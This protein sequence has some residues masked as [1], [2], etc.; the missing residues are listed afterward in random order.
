M[1]IY[2]IFFQNLNQEKK[3][4][5]LVFILLSRGEMGAQESGTRVELLVLFLMMRS[6]MW[7]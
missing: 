7:K 2:E 3:R 5:I 6:V 1:K 4:E